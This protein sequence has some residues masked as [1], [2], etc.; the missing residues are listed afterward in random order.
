MSWS[1]EVFD[2]RREAAQPL[3]FDPWQCLECSACG[4]RL[5]KEK[6]GAFGTG[7]FF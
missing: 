2:T 6:S 4:W 1:E 5:G 7:N 3:E